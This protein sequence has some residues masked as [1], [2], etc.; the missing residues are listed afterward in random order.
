M[1]TASGYEILQRIAKDIK[2]YSPDA[3]DGLSP[4]EIVEAMLFFWMTGEEGTP[5]RDHGGVRWVADNGETIAAWKTNR[6][7]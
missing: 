2:G 4:S 1:R 5:V 7:L 6:G 3:W